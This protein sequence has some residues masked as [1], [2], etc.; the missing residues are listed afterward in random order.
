[1]PDL[2]QPTEALIERLWRMERV[3]AGVSISGVNMTRKEHWTQKP[4]NPDGPEAAETIKSLKATIE[5]LEARVEAAR[6]LLFDSLYHL[7]LDEPAK[8][9]HSKA[10]QYLYSDGEG[11]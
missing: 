11:G 6:A 4:I 2:T 7:R 9:Y 10:V 8:A 1:M 5:R 3:T